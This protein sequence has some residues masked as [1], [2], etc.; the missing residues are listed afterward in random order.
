MGSLYPSEP[1]QCS[2]ETGEGQS[3]NEVSSAR[4]IWPC[5]QTTMPGHADLPYTSIIPTNTKEYSQTIVPV[6]HPHILSF[7]SLQDL[8]VGIS[9]NLLST[10]H[11]C[12]LEGSLLWSLS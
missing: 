5:N 9:C 12:M 3:G 6:S 11:I 10:F 4:G 7:M 2:D 1:V 8:S